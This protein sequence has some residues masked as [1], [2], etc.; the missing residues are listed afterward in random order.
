MTDKTPNTVE[1]LGKVEEVTLHKGKHYHR[2]VLP[3]LDEYERPA[4][5]VVVS[6][7]RLQEPGQELHV[8]ARIRGFSRTFTRKTGETGHEVKTHFEAIA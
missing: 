7:S 4:A 6:N 5:A 2:L 3:A 8:N 1:I